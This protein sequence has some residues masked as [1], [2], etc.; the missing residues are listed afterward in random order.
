MTVQSTV[1]GESRLPLFFGSA[2]APLFGCYH[3]PS[4]RQKRRCAVV[5]C[6]PFGQEYI[7]T[8]RSFVQ[9]AKRLAASGFPVLRF[10]YFG[11]G[12]SAGG[13]GEG[14]LRRWVADVGSAVEEV[15]RQSGLRPVCLVGL[16][17]GGA[18]AMT[19]AAERG[20]VDSLVL[21]DPVIRGPDYRVQLRA[22]QE[23]AVRFGYMELPSNNGDA[24]MPEEV[25][26]FPYTPGLAEDLADVDLSSIDASVAGSVLL[27]ESSGPPGLE[28]LCARLAGS[29]QLFEHR[30][31]AE[32][33]VW[34]DEPSRGIVPFRLIEEIVAWLTRVY[35]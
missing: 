34:T 29:A 11:C 5:L 14:R 21:W 12:D 17:L 6:H 10:D 16:R 26:G 28:A 31:L 30:H 18:L 33:R 4:H 24:G 15:R 32:R 7:R 1:R 8:H 3:P 20:D 13:S 35:V 23:E 19:A 27:I 2:S 22:M 25:L 9:L